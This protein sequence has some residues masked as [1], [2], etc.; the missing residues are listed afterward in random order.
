MSTVSV[1]IPSYNRADLLPHA[2][3]SVLDQSYTDLEIIVVDDGSTDHTRQVIQDITHPKVRYIYQENRG[4]SGARNTGIE[5][6]RGEFIAF[7][8]SDDIIYPNKLISQIQQFDKNP[9]LGLVA[10]G[11]NHIDDYGRVLQEL[12]P[13]NVWPQLDLDTWIKVCPVVPASVLVRRVWIEKV[14]HFDEKFRRVEDWDMWLRLAHAGCKMAWTQEIVCGYRLHTGQ[15]VRDAT[16]QKKGYIAVLDKFFTNPQSNNF[17]L[18]KSQIYA[19]AYLRGAYLEYKYSQLVEA[20]QDVAQAIQLYPNILKSKGD[21]VLRDLVALVTSPLISD[22]ISHLEAVF[23][24]L[25]QTAE[26][27]INRKKQTFTLAYEATFFRS[28]H[29]KEWRRT[30]ESFFKVVVSKPSILLNKGVIVALVKA[31]IN[32]IRA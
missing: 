17:H 9:E 30:L 16:S 11:Y 8:D 4:L 23:A 15:M 26:Y 7:L 14:G 12:L 31:C 1:V 21:N 18:P 20:K 13:W 10:G 25:P 29:R 24:N 5:V 27:V 3:Q 19:E 22:P 2:I 6:S 32:L 28:Y